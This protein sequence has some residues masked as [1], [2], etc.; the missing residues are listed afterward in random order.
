[1][2]GSEIPI[3]ILLVAGVSSFAITA[4]G[5]LVGVDV[6][7]QIQFTYPAATVGVVAI[8][9]AVLVA[10]WNTQAA[11]KTL[12]TAALVFFLNPVLCHATA[13]AARIRQRGRL[14]P[15]EGEDLSV[16]RREDSA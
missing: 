3:A 1:M 12:V 10:D 8:A 4:V 14:M 15:R 11:A 13:R 5:L 16:I 6:Y 7:E 2:N 9:A